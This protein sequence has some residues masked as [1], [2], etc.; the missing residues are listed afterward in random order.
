[1]AGQ[2]CLSARHTSAGIADF[3]NDPAKGILHTLHVDS[4]VIHETDSEEAKSDES[5]WLRYTLDMVGKTS[6]PRD[7]QGNQ[8]YPEE[9]KRLAEN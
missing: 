6:W 3:R 2:R 4:K 9:F 7:S 1:V 8:I 5:R